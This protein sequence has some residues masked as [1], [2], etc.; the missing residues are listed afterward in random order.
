MTRFGMVGMVIVTMI[1]RL[2]GQT[3]TRT[4]ATEDCARGGAGDW[5][6]PPPPTAAEILAAQPA[7]VRAAVKEHDQKGEVAELPDASLCALSV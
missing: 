6:R 7:E 4:A 2:C 5:R 3:T 1:G